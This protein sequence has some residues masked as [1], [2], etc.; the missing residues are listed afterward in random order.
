MVYIYK[1]LFFFQDGRGRI[2]MGPFITHRLNSYFMSTLA[3]VSITVGVAVEEQHAVKAQ[4]KFKHGPA[5]SSCGSV[6]A[7]QLNN[8]LFSLLSS[9]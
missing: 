5:V 3:L 1:F 6:A 8:Q 9:I 4:S 7:V 2:Y